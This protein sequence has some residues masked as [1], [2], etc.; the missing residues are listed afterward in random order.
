[1][2]HS[3]MVER[4]DKSTAEGSSTQTLSDEKSPEPSENSDLVGKITE[5]PR[6]SSSDRQSQGD[7][8]TISTQHLKK[9]GIIPPTHEPQPPGERNPLSRSGTLLDMAEAKCSERQGG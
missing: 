5:Q 6:H 1:M 8:L 9:L 3:Q 7:N 4:F 2:E